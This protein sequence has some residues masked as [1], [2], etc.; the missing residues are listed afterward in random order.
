MHEEPVGTVSGEGGQRREM[1]GK[2][3][4]TRLPVPFNSVLALD[5]WRTARNELCKEM[6]K[7][8]LQA[9]EKEISRL[10][11]RPAEGEGRHCSNG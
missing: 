3:V 6:R 9:G 1:G 8:Y 5:H 4:E 11:L 2:W 7:L 10:A